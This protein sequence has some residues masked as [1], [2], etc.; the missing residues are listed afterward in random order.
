MPERIRELARK[1]FRLWRENTTL[2]GLD[3]KKLNGQ[4]HEVWQVRIGIHFRALC[5]KQEDT[6][7]WFWIGTKGECSKMV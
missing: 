1:N 5:V 4:R 3:F 2:P 7:V 6:F